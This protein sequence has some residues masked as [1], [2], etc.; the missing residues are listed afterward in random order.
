MLVIVFTI[1]NDG[2]TQ[3]DRVVLS[4]SIAQRKRVELLVY[5]VC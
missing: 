1:Y 4:Q 2:V 3:C 5:W